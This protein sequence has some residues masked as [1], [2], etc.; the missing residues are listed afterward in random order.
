MALCAGTGAV[1]CPRAVF[2]PRR[3]RRFYSGKGNYKKAKRMEMNCYPTTS[4]SS[5]LSEGVLLG[6]I[7]TNA[8]SEVP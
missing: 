6:G 3:A 8:K 1:S 5:H 7:E 2:G 4:V